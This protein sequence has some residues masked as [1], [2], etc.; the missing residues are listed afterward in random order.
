MKL[1]DRLGAEIVEVCSGEV[2]SSDPTAV[3]F[4]EE[5]RV[6]MVKLNLAEFVGH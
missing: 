2:E 5:G 3:F 1:K 4:K 6:E